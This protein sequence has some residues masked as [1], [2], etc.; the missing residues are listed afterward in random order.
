MRKALIL[1]LPLFLVACSHWDNSEEAVETVDYSCGKQNIAVTYMSP[2]L[3]IANINGINNVL[4]PAV[5]ADGA[6]YEN[7]ATGVVFWNKGEN[8]YLQI[9]DKSYPSCVKQVL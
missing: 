9:R 4:T 8:N 6:K 5:S 3:L 1:A 7:L 2:G